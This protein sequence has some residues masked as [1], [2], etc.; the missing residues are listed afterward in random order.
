MNTILFSKEIPL[1]KDYDVIVLGGGPAG[2]AASAA[3]AR[4]GASTLLIEST[5]M[6]G[7]MGTAGLVSSWCPF[8]DKEKIIYRGLAETV[9]NTLKDQMP[10]VPP[11]KLDWVPIEPEALKRVYDDMVTQYGARVLFNTVLSDVETDGNGYVTHIIVGNKSGMSALRAKAYV[12]CTGDADL[13]VW[14]GASYEKGDANAE[15]MPATLCFTL[16]NV[17]E[18]A[19][20]YDRRSG[21]KY[22]GIHPNNKNSIVYE[23]ANDDRYP[24]IRD[25]HLCCQLIG[26]KTV[27]F[28][29]GH[30][31]NVDNTSPESVSQALIEGR[32][33]ADEYRRAFAEYFQ[34]AFSSAFLVGTAALMGV[35]ES[36]RIVGDYRM[37]ISDYLS[38]RSFGDEI[39]RNSYYIDVHAGL[40]EAKAELEHGPDA[41]GR[42]RHYEKGE[43]HGIPYRSLIPKGVKNVLVAGRSIACDRE[44][45]AS[46]RVMP[47]CLCT[48]EA[49]GIASAFA[50]SLFGGDVRSVDPVS[51]RAALRQHGAY[52]PEV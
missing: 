29:A 50:S 9:F 23:M 20:M 18:Y 35:R 40:D 31:W 11:E 6:L 28:N 12:D 48:G 17:D 45:Q 47:N 51:L 42:R 4:E 32:L 27:S 22:G 5:G 16:T 43:S 7:G 3:A 10:H 30:I 38:R 44:I 21:L 1:C 49:A 26:P 15:V 33:I 39:S 46:V 8:W 34:S 2:C 41:A 37:T 36:R 19:Y 52:L 25:I 13:A 14:A 24:L